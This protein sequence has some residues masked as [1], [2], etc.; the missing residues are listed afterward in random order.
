MER[1]GSEASLEAENGKNPP[2]GAHG[3]HHFH[4]PSFS[5]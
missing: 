5:P 4:R 2:P 1:R 3:L